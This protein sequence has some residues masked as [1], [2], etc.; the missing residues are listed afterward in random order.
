MH[1]TLF[2]G[3]AIARTDSDERYTPA[4]VFNGLGLRFDLDVAHPADATTHVPCERY[5]T[6]DDDGLTAPW[7]GLVWCNPPFS[8]ATPWAHRM[9]EHGNGLLLGPVSNGAWTQ[10]ILAAC[11]LAWLMRDFPFDHPTHAGKRSSMPL[12]MYALGEI[13][14][15]ALRR[16]AHMY[17]DAGTLMQRAS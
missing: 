6:R 13:A 2:G 4:W 12:V 9:I 5:Y 15:P 11:D 14:A 17:P 1:E 10:R 8:N 16:A 3:V 7:A